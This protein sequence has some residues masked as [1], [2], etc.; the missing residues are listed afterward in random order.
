MSEGLPSSTSSPIS[1]SP[2]DSNDEDIQPGLEA[3]VIG[4]T[5]DDYAKVCGAFRYVGKVR[6]RDGLIT[7]RREPKHAD[8]ADQEGHGVWVFNGFMHARQVI[9]GRWHSTG[10][11]GHDQKLEGIFCISRRPQEFETLADL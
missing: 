9:V 2:S 6:F 11:L 5:E 4:E 10:V 3:Y 1:V 8:H 7:L